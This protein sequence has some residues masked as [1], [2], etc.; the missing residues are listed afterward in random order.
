MKEST[1]PFLENGKIYAIDGGQANLIA[2]KYGVNVYACYVGKNFEH[3]WL[4]NSE[5]PQKIIGDAGLVQDRGVVNQEN[6][7]VAQDNF[8]GRGKADFDK[9]ISRGLAYRLTICKDLG[10]L[11][12]EVPAEV[13]NTFPKL[14]PFIVSNNERLKQTTE[15]KHE[16]VVDDIWQ[17]LNNLDFSS[18]GLEDDSNQVK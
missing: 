14:L 9:I 15:E 13:W 4:T 16:K 12:P 2:S 6:F 1:Y 5:N 17:S 18:G 11:I 8:E 7:F 3:L 10:N